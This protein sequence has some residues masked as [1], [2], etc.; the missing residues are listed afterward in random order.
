MDTPARR[1]AHDLN[2][3]AFVIT[4]YAQRLEESIPDSDPRREDVNAILQAAPRLVEIVSRIRALESASSD[5][6]GRKPRILLVEDEASVRELLKAVLTR[7]GYHVDVGCTGDE[8]L[9]LCDSL[10]PPDLLI[11]DLIMPGASGPVI[12]ERLRRRAPHAKV[13]LMSGYA[14]HPLL[15][16]AQKA[17]EPCLVKPFEMSQFSDA[18]QQLIG[19]AA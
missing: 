17:G 18:V 15:E 10:E 14:D 5:D 16:A 19:R 12:A 4:G 11:T 1:L 3:V 13:L 8:G 7:R 9:A 6:A 2:N